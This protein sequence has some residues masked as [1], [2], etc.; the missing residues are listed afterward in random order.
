LII[1]E[2]KEAGMTSDGGS[3]AGDKLDKPKDDD[4]KDSGDDTKAK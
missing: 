3:G 4:T 2:F 1:N